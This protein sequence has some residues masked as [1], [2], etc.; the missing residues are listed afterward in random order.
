MPLLVKK[1]AP[2]AIIFVVFFAACYG[3]KEFGY[4]QGKSA[5]DAD[6]R[7][8]DIEQLTQ[9]LNTTEQLTRDANAASL[10]LGKTI[11]RRVL[12]DN[13]ATEDIRHA[14]STTA[15]LRVEC[16][17]PDNVML[18]LAAARDRA[19]SAAASGITSA[20]PTTA[21]TE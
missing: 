18:Q 7:E 5:A 4:L 19:N 3:S 16:R 2:W 20:V 21:N 12:A 9:M 10:Q 13:K 11:S 15:H 14:L 6:H 8:Q 1:I 17:V